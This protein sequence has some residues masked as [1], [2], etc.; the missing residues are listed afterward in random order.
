MSPAVTGSKWES[1][2]H[3]QI[4]VRQTALFIS[5]DRWRVEDLRKTLPKAQ[6]KEGLLVNM[7]GRIDSWLKEN[8]LVK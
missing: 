5:E 7:T 1:L 3:R 8:G 4:V 6:V 2:I